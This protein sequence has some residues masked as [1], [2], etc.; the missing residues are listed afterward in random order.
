MNFIEFNSKFPTEEAV[1]DYFIEQR[2]PE[3]I[4]CP[5]CGNES[6][7]HRKN[8][9]FFDC[10]QCNNTFSIFK[11]TVFAKSRTDLRK[12]MYA[13]Q[14]FLNG[15]KGISGYQ[16]QRE[17]L[18]TYK[19]AW[20]MLQQIRIAMSNTGNTELFEAVVEIDE[21]YIGGKPRKGSNKQA[22]GSKRGRGT[23][24]TPIVGVIE[25]TTQKVHAKVALPNRDGQKLSGIQ[26]LSILNDVCKKNAT[27]ISD[28]FKGYNILKNT[29]YVHLVIDHSKGFCKDFIHTNNIESFWAT[30]KRGIYGIYHHVSVKYLQRYINEFCFRYNNR[31]TNMFS[32]VLRQGVLV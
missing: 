31:K 25:R 13:L 3:G 32:L 2:Y 8:K 29:E 10:K 16:L 19:T 4:K 28:E 11:D 26:L 18:T 23:S 30:L 24:K 5:H 1:I 22:S 15:K 21:T 9:K 12:W 20:R 6:I 7:Y 14:L 27:V 17:I